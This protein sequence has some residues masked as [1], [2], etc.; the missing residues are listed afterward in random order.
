MQRTSTK[1]PTR[2]RPRP[3][4]GPGKRR[5]QFRCRPCYMGIAGVWG[6]SEHLWLAGMKPLP[7]HLP[8]GVQ[9][10]K[11]T[12]TYLLLG[13]LQELPPQAKLD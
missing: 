4:P 13:L 7:C 3:S 11:L 1:P 5:L 10:G 6:P 12:A 8:K 2:R 9:L